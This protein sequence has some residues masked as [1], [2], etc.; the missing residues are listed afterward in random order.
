MTIGPG[1][2]QNQFLGHFNPDIMMMKTVVVFAKS[3]EANLIVGGGVVSGVH[4]AAR[5]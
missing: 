1:I 4:C 3:C 5:S 2:S